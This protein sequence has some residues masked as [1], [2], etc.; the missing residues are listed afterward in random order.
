[1]SKTFT[2]TVSFDF[3]LV[4][5]DASVQDVLQCVQTA[6]GRD[7]ITPSQEYI[8]QCVTDDE[9]LVALW[10]KT[11]REGVKQY[12]QEVHTDTKAA[13]DGDSFTFSPV[14]VT[15]EAKKRA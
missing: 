1:M 12:L 7:V 11:V 8:T 10:R 14:Q 3:S 2:G 5:T 6:S 15:V 13:G 9:K 4:L